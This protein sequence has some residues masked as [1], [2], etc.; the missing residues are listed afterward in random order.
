METIKTRTGGLIHVLSNHSYA[1]AIQYL[2]MQAQLIQWAVEGSHKDL[3]ENNINALLSMAKEQ[4]TKILSKV[5][6]DDGKDL[7]MRHFV[8][9]STI[10]SGCFIDRLNQCLS[11][12]HQKIEEEQV[13]STM[14]KKLHT[15]VLGIP[16]KK[17]IGKSAKRYVEHGLPEYSLNGYEKKS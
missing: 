8:T 5:K 11:K 12:C 7:G 3:K 6:H 13:G 4:M 17:A 1:T 9:T 16:Q 2:I 15:Y 10:L 14:T